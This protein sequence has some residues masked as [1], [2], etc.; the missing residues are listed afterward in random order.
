MSILLMMTTDRRCDVNNDKSKSIPD[1][2]SLVFGR[3][4]YLFYT[5]VLTPSTHKFFPL[6]RRMVLMKLREVNQIFGVGNFILFCWLS[7]FFRDF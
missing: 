3:F 4:F 1:I 2:I 7:H 6:H 5:K